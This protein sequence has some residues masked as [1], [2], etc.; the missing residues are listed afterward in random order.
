VKS[1]PTANLAI[2]RRNL[3]NDQLTGCVVQRPGELG[4]K[5]GRVAAT[6]ILLKRCVANSF[7]AILLHVMVKL[8]GDQ[9]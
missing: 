4:A 2:R 7:K 5:R 1:F 3:S 8:E 9:C 6:A